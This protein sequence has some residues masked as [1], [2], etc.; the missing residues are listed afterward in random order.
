ME[1]LIILRRPKETIQ[2]ILRIKKTDSVG[3]REKKQR[4][5]ESRLRPRNIRSIK[6]P[7]G[8]RTSRTVRNSKCTGM[9]AYTRN[10]RNT[11]MKKPVKEGILIIG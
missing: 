3:A 6:R 1:M 10:I 11:N 2:G 8:I 7:K 5:V 9:K 4:N